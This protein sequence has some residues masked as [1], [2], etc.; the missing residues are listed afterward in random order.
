MSFQVWKGKER[1]EKRREVVV[2]WFVCLVVYEFLLSV[3]IPTV[4][5]WWRVTYYYPAWQREHFPGFGSDL[6]KHVC[7]R[8]CLHLHACV[9]VNCMYAGICVCVC[10]YCKCPSNRVSLLQS[11]TVLQ[12]VWRETFEVQHCSKKKPHPGQHPEN[13]TPVKKTKE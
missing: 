10:I 6:S 2:W 1:R 3:Y 4:A 9:S 8:V 12:A 13:P 7:V 11:V 5:K